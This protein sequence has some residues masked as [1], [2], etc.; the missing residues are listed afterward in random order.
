MFRL[1]SNVP[2]TSLLS[3]WFGASVCFD[4]KVLV[5]LAVAFALVLL[6]LCSPPVLE[7]FESAL[8][9]TKATANC[10]GSCSEDT[11]VLA[12]LDIVMVSPVFM[13]LFMPMYSFRCLLC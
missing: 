10:Y 12:I 4:Y 8:L 6:T 13:L 9:I 1:S 2:C 5:H 11:L 7:L 3:S